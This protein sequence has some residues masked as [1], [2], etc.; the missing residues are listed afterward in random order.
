M[1]SDVLFTGYHTKGAPCYLDLSPDVTCLR[2]C[3]SD[4][5]AVKLPFFPTALWK[6]GTTASPDLHSRELW[7]PPWGQSTNSR[8]LGTGDSSLLRVIRASVC[9]H[10]CGFT[11]A[12][13]EELGNGTWD[14]GLLAD[15]CSVYANV[16]QDRGPMTQM[17]Q[18]SRPHSRTRLTCHSTEIS[19]SMNYQVLQKLVLGAEAQATGQAPVR[20]PVLTVT[21]TPSPATGKPHARDVQSLWDGPDPQPSTSSPQPWV[22]LGALS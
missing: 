15:M 3:A 5:S 11:D 16:T 18:S 10:L 17:R 8:R 6:E 22:P 21:S 14:L 19:A 4:F 12:Q 7:V 2:S 13:S 1:C 9:L 20:E